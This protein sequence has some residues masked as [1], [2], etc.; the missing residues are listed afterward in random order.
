MTSPKNSVCI[1]GKLKNAKPSEWNLISIM[2]AIVYPISAVISISGVLTG[3]I[4]SNT[5]FLVFFFTLTGF[6][7]YSTIESIKAGHAFK[8]SIWRSFFKATL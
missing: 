5:L 1:C 2:F 8:C 6:I 7:I 4:K 3:D